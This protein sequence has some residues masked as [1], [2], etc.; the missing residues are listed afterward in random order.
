MSLQPQIV[1]IPYDVDGK[2]AQVLEAVRQRRRMSYDKMSGRYTAW[3]EMEERFRAYIKPTEGDKKRA[4]LRK[5]G[6]TQYTTLEIPYSYAILLTLHT[7]LTSV[8]LGRAPIFQYE[9]R[10]G[11]P[12]QN[13]KAVEAVIDYQRAVGEWLVPLYIWLMDAHKYGIGVL[14]SHW[15]EDYVVTTESTVEPVTYF[16]IPTGKTRVRRDT[17]RIPG[18]KGNK[19]FNVRPQDWFPDPRVSLARFQEGEF[20][21]RRLEVGWNTILKRA[22]AGLYYNVEVLK[23]KIKTRYSPERDTGSSQLVLPDG[24]ETLYYHGANNKEGRTEIKN[25]VELFEFEVEL[26]PAAWGFSKSRSPEKWVITVANDEVVVSVEPLGLLHDKFT[27]DILE[28]EVEGYALAKRSQLE[29]LA[30]LNDTLSWLFNSH[31]HNVRRVLN[32]QLIVDPSGVVMKDLNDPNAGRLVRLKPEAYG[33]DPKLF[34]HQLQV[35]DITQNH[36]RDAQLVA[37]MMQRVS[38]VVNDVMGATQQGSR[39]TATEVRTNSGF[40][41]N[42]MK[43]VTEYNSAMGFAPLAQ[44]LLQTT[45]QKYDGEQWFRVAGDLMK[46]KAPM[47]VTPADIAGAYDFVPVDGTMPVDRYAQA[48]LWKEMLQVL[49]SGRI[50]DPTTGLPAQIDIFGI[51][52][53]IAHLSG[54]KNLDEFK[55][56]VVPDAQIAGGVRAGNLVPLP[57]GQGGQPRAGGARS[58]EGAAGTPPQIPQSG[59]IPGVGRAA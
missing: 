19:L 5:E 45:Q 49:A 32:D 34:V 59:G 57:G 1:E 56:N 28:H 22:A 23:S 11:E 43:T 8:F 25:Y 51:L 30:P 12:Q 2:H 9:S 33:K 52:K 14:G 53:H 6:K 42:R 3:A 58:G 55:V 10:H 36:M 7:Y 44:K 4:E 16:G 39:R 15:T 41:M 35:V 48:M 54:V 21:G 17:R 40:S 37:E 46:T 29:I 26:V 47:R 18:Y 31:M 38:G 13:V 50:V 27:F 20:C 24:M